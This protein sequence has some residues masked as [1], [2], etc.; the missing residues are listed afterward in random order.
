MIIG[1]LNPKTRIESPSRKESLSPSHYLAELMKPPSLPPNIQK[2]TSPR[3]SLPHL[4][5]F[6]LIASS[7]R[8]K[9]YFSVA[10]KGQISRLEEENSPLLLKPKL[11][12]R[13]MKQ[14]S[15]IGLSDQT[16]F[17]KQST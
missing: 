8:Q 3:L 11:N 13:H 6:N 4:D 1:P 12:R 16:S 14:L 2:I 15:T 7:S 10:S 9:N 5:A 17:E